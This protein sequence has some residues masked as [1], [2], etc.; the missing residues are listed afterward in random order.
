MGH[1]S[2]SVL[3]CI[4]ASVGFPDIGHPAGVLPRLSECGAL[5]AQRHAWLRDDVCDLLWRLLHLRAHPPRRPGTL[6]PKA[7]ILMRRQWVR[8]NLRRTLIC[9]SA[10]VY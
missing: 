9:T 3:L 7:T 10:S 8:D 2:V 4:L 5:L 1:H 6:H